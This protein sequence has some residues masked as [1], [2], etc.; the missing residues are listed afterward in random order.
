MKRSYNYQSFIPEEV[1]KGAVKKLINYLLSASDDL[2]GS[3]NDIHITSDGYCTIVEWNDVSFEHEDDC[4]K[5]KFVDY[6]EVIMKDVEFP[7]GHYETLYPE[8]VEEKLREWH[9]EHPTWKM[10]EYGHW[11]DTVEQ[12]KEYVYCNISEWSDKLVD[13]QNIIR[14]DNSA[15]AQDVLNKLDNDALLFR[16]SYIIVGENVLD[17]FFLDAWETSLD[18][19]K[20]VKAGDDVVFNLGGIDLTIKNPNKYNEEDSDTVR[21]HI[22]LDYAKDLKNRI[23][24]LTDDNYPL[25]VFN[26][27]PTNKK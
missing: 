22:Q 13:E 14:Y 10:G 4:G 24:L 16:T 12:H 5:F 21:V 2:E 6:D 1:K 11:Y 19:C 9:Q 18:A 26:L 20:K 7:D 15:T 17:T 23:V 3:Y 27:I 25:G 8:D